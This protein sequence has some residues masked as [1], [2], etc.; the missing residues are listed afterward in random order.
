MKRYSLQKYKG[1][2]S[3][4]ECPSCGRKRMFVRYV[5]EGGNP[6]DPTVGRCNR[7]SKC[8]YHLTPK[9]WFA[10]H[11]TPQQPRYD[12]R[13]TPPSPPRPIGT[14]PIEYVH[15]SI[16]FGSNL[17]LFL[18]TLFDPPTLYRLLDDYLLGAAKG[19]AIIYWQIDHAGNARTGKVMQ[20][21]PHTGH[22]CKHE[23][24]GIDWI[25]AILKRRGSLPEDYNLSQ[26]LFGE[27]LLP[28]Y[29]HKM[30]VVV[31]SEK[32]ALIG[33]AHYPQYLWLATG[34][35]SL[36]SYDKMRVLKGRDVLLLPDVDAYTEWRE[37]VGAFTFCRTCTVADVLERKASPQEREMQIDIADWVV[38]ELL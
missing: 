38:E 13:P 2:A 18:L 33:S 24:G 11:P 29:P 36:L 30:V 1:V 37:R 22:R 27:H 4:H 15:R 3:R 35:K 16:C 21:D 10:T 7:E 19:G 8:G 17:V 34:G 32:S 20:Y 26:C 28:R 9:Q 12:Y 23:K 5:D 31:E 6:I 25:H 14:I